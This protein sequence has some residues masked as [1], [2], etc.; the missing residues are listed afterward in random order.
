[1]YR[2]IYNEEKF[3][4]DSSESI[5]PFLMYSRTVGISLSEIRNLF[6]EIRATNQGIMPKATERMN[7]VLPNLSGVMGPL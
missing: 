6:D 4:R 1:M 7:N 5:E 2:N 3:K